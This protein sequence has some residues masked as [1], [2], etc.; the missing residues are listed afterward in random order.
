MAQVKRNSLICLAL[1]LGTM[2]LYAP[3][4]FCDFTNF[5]DP[6]Y[7]TQNPHVLAGLTLDG[8][9]WSFQAGYGS[10]W[11][12]LTWQSHML[13]CQIFGLKP[14]AHHLVNAL[15]HAGNV[16]LLFL[17]LQRMTGA[18]W[19]SVLVA[20]LFACHPLHVESVAWIAERKDVLS[21]FFFLLTILL[22]GKSC[23]K[24]PVPT[25]S[26]LASLSPAYV[27]AIFFFALGLMAKP[28]LVTLPVVL[29][30]LDYWPLQR[31]SWRDRLVEK[32][33]FFVLSF[34]SCVITIVAQHRGGAILSLEQAPFKGRFI[35]AL[36]SNFHY[37]EKLV[38]PTNLSVI[39]PPQA[40]WDAKEI[41]LALAFLIVFSVLA[42]RWI[43]TRPWWVVGWVWFLLTLGPV[44]GLVQVGQQ[45]MADRY[46]YIPSIG[47]LVMLCW[48]PPEKFK[49]IILTV[50][51]AVV[52]LFCALTGR[53]LL[54]WQNSGTLYLHSLAVTRDNDVA[55]GNYAAYLRTFNQ[56]EQARLELEETVR[57]APNYI[58]AQNLLGRILMYQEKYDRAANQ[59]RIVIRLDPNQAE[60]YYELALACTWQQDF[61]EA[62][63]HYREALGL[64]PDYPEVLN[65]L[66]WIYAANARADLRNGS[67]AVKLA[68]RACALTEFKQPGLIGT[69]AAAYAEAGL[70]PEAIKT[71]EQA[72]AAALARGDKELAEKNTELLKLYHAGHAYHEP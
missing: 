21:T 65:N 72:R 41:I 62:A 10:N 51:V 33:P 26:L 9:K 71:A 35:N 19:R 7:V 1:I 68:T 58:W 59:F 53:Q 43:K 15:F 30:L 2:C 23:A 36:V 17:V 46:M 20:V 32:L 40:T 22:Y 64:Q 16:A 25:K 8:L 28:M 37:F 24:L 47:L 49:R 6:I 70:F 29:L 45:A 60:A 3:V 27:L 5:D 61:G 67:E 14:S 12:P 69:L 54:V 13:D 48:W 50:M 57:L 44:I 52:A 18:V 39:Y 42:L 4:W 63:A 31:F 55:H 11:H 66:A 38:W 56:F 34:A